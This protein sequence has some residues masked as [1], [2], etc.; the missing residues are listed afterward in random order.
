MKGWAAS[1]AV[2]Y[3]KDAGGQR[4]RRAAKTRSRSPPPASSS[5]GATSK[6]S[7]PLRSELPPLRSDAPGRA[8]PTKGVLPHWDGAEHQ[9]RA[10]AKF[11]ADMHAASSKPTHESHL[12]TMTKALQAWGFSLFPPTPAKILALGATFKEGGYRSAGNFFTSYRTEAQR[13]GYEITGVMHRHF[14][15]SKRSCNR[16]LGGPIRARPLPLDRLH[17]LPFGPDPVVAGGPVGPRAAIQVGAW[18]LTREVELSTS[19]A[20]LVELSMNSG[21]QLAARWHLPASKTDIEAVGMARTLVCHCSCPPR[22]PGAGVKSCPAHVLAEHLLLLRA[23]FPDRH[24]ALGVPDLD[25]PLFPTCTGGVVK[26]EAMIE[27][28]QKAGEALGISCEAPDG[29]ERLSGHSLRVTGAQGLAE[30]G[31]HLWAIQLQ[32]RWGSETVKKYL[33][34]SP[35]AHPVATTSQSMDLEALIEQLLPAISAQTSETQHHQQ[36]PQRDPTP[37]LSSSQTEQLEDLLSEEAERSRISASSSSP[38]SEFALR[39]A[40]LIIN[41]NSGFTHRAVNSSHAQCGWNYAA[42]NARPHILSSFEDGPEVWG[43]C[44]ERC[45]EAVFP[46]VRSAPK[47]SP[48]PW[49]RLA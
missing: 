37:S 44:C 43:S 16:G 17:L 40:H 7:P 13:H 27:T 14:E 42:P 22:W 33:R 23:L 5:L 47:C 21:G 19:R 35:L 31:W 46:E 26:K 8:A 28:I 2:Q 10:M 9:S 4:G 6:A 25:L 1:P 18:W 15:D 11:R 36:Q 20:R 34:E 38:S 48:V 12:N 45:F 3:S 41:L 49:R 30:L 32:G 39:P 24:D 29:S